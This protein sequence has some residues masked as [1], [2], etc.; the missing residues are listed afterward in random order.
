MPTSNS[1]TSGEVSLAA[2][3]TREHHEIDAAIE[4]YLAD[5]TSS[6][7]VR[8]TRPLLKAMEALRRHIYLEEEIVFPRLPEQ[9]LMMA[10]MVMRREHGQL[11]RQM[12]DL[13]AILA[14][15]SAETAG[16][17]AACTEI[18][19]LLEKH[20]SKEEPIIYPH[21]DASLTSEEQARIRWLFESGTLPEGWICDA[22][23]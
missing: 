10:L 14:D 8:R 9:E 16:I 21:M 7:P 15:P 19:T 12:D 17:D 18:L 11:W 20:N 13:A 3:F 22:L 6:D 1:T 4:E 2:A 5:T 23:R